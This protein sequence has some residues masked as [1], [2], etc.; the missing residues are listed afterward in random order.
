MWQATHSLP[1]RVRRVMRVLLERR[2]CAD[3]S[4]TVGAV[5]RAGTSRCGGLPQVGVVRAC[6]GRRGSSQQVT[7]RVYIRLCTKSLPCIRFL[8]AV[9]SREVRE[10]RLAELVLLELPEVLQVQPDAE[11]DRPVVVRARRSDSS[12]GWPC[13]WHW[14]Q[15]SLACDGVEPRRVDDVRARRLSRRARRPGRGTSRSRRSTP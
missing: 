8:C 12:S 3:R 1:A 14:M 10:R 6:R 2:A 7:P 13:E 5:A 9:P 15:T 11:A 4:A